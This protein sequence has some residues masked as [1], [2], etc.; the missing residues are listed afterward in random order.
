MTS[1]PVAADRPGKSP[2]ELQTIYDDAAATFERFDRLGHLLV[3]RYRRRLFGRASGR[4]LDVACGTGANFRYLP[5]D[6][7]VVGVD[8]SPAMLAAADREAARRGRD[9]TL[10][11]ADA[12]SLPF[13]DDSFDFVV[14]SLSTCTFPD[15]VAVLREM[16]RV[17]A[18]D[19]YVLLLEHGRSSVGP[20]AALQD[21]FADHHFESM[22][23]RWNQEPVDVVRAAGLD[24]RAHE[25]DL[26]GVLTSMVVAPD[27]AAGRV[28]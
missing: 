16:A 2:G 28:E 18:P 8:L 5:A 20:I 9:V 15:P 19:G 25:R 13:S 24:V 14:S 11:R 21:R 27:D 3:G 12:T 26:L 7:E 23:C 6:C 10:Q 22:G 1:R 17:C 4:V